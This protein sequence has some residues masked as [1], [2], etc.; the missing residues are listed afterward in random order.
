M[1][2]TMRFL[3]PEADWAK[4]TMTLHD[5]QGLWGGLA[6]TITGLGRVDVEQRGPA[7]LSGHFTGELSEAET[8]ALFQLFIEH[9]F[10]TLAIPFRPGIP[11]EAHPL[12][13]LTNARGEAHAV[14]K[15]ARQAE[16]RFD[17]VAR[18]LREAA[19]RLRPTD[20]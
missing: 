15:W 14:G 16:A 7:L 9:D 13:T 12:L 6:V 4:A 2:E 19:A 11:D 8:R 18:A 10:L 3:G 5:I 20:L 17:A 1:N